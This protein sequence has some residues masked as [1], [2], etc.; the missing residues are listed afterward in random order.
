ME[1]ILVKPVRKVGK[2]GELIRVKNGFAR[3]YLIPK[4]L[5]IRATE[6]NKQL[7]EK[8]KAEFEAKNTQ[9]RLEAESIAKMVVDKE[10]IFIKQSSD[11]GRLFGSVTNKEI[12]SALTKLVSYNISYSNIPIEAQIKSTG[13]FIVEIM[14]HAEV[15][16][17]V[18]IV[19]ARSESEANNA[20]RTHKASIENPSSQEQ[21]EV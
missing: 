13:V 21:E 3:N 19:V 7:I 6:T 20:L 14:L 2:I 9:A 15:T 4:N 1:V 18:L 16:V 5:A 8:K 10:L 11:D 12:A 17:P